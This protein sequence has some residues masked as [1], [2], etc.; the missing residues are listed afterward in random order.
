MNRKDLIIFL[1]AQLAVVIAVGLIFKI[2]ED[3]QIAATVAGALFV[4]L[5]IGFAFRA[6][7]WWRWRYSLSFWSALFFGAAVAM[8]MLIQRVRH[9]GVDFSEVR[10]WWMSGPEFHSLSS[11]IFMVMTLATLIDLVRT[12]IRVPARGGMPKVHYR[13]ID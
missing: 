6:V 3:R 5:S 13:R 9:W 4:I 8:P 1:I 10:V 2:I 12:L 11:K 7:A